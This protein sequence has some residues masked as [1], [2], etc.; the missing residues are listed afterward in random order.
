MNIAQTIPPKDVP[1][2][3]N[4]PKHLDFDFLRE[5]GLRHIQDLSGQ[6]WTDHNV[7]DPG[8]TI[9]EVLCYALTDLTYRTQLPDADLF[10]PNPK[11]RATTGDDNF[12]TAYTMLSCNPLTELDW[13]KL[14]LDIKGV[15]NAWFVPIETVKTVK[16]VKTE[17][18]GEAKD[19]DKST[20]L[21]FDKIIEQNTEKQLWKN[22]LWETESLVLLDKDKTKLTFSDSFEKANKDFQQSVKYPLSIRGVYKIRLELEQNVEDKEP[23]LAEVNRRLAGHRNLCEDFGDISIVEDE[24][25]TICGEFELDATAQP[26]TVMLDLFN[27]IQE[28]FSPTIKF[29]TLRQMLDNGRTMEEIFEGR[30]MMPESHGFVDTA[31]LE[32]LKLPTEIR[33]SDLY[34]LI[35]GDDLKENP[36]GLQKIAGI[37]AI[38]KLLVINPK[39]DKTEQGQAWKV[40]ITEGARP[41][42]NVADSIASITFF[43][44]GVPYKVNSARVVNLFEKRLENPSKVSYNLKEER[45]K[46]RQNLDF[47]APT[48]EYRADLGDHVSIQGDFPVVYGIGESAVPDSGGTKRKAQAAQ[49]K[50][51]LTFFDHLLANY[52]AQVANVRTL[53]SP[54]LT[55]DGQPLPAGDAAEIAWLGK[56]PDVFAPLAPVADLRASIPNADALFGFARKENAVQI[57]ASASPKDKPLFGE[58]EEIAKSQ[59]T[60]ATPH[61]RDRALRQ[62]IADVDSDLVRIDTKTLSKAGELDRF[63]F[64]FVSQLGRTVTIKSLKTYETIS[65]AK[66]AAQAVRFVATL[67]SS[68]EKYDHL[69]ASP[70]YYDFK[71]IEDMGDVVAVTGESPPYYDFKLIYRP[72]QYETYLRTIL[73]DEATFFKQKNR[74]F[75]HLLSRF[76]EDFTDYTLLTFA[77]LRNNGLQIDTDNDVALSRRFALDKAHFLEKYPEIS[78]NRAK[79]VDFSQPLWTDKNQSGLENRVSKLIGIADRDTKTLNYFDIAARPT[80]YRFVIS[81]VYYKKGAA[82]LESIYTP[83]MRSSLTFESATK[84]ETARLACLE[85][86]KN[87]AHFELTF[88]TIEKVYGFR[89]LDDKGCPV[90]ESVDTFGSAALRDSKLDYTHGLFEGDGVMR[91]FRAHTEG[92]FF[93]IADGSSGQL[94]AAK[95]AADEKT[96]LYSLME[97]LQALPI[98]SNWQPLDEATERGYSFQIVVNQKVVAY[99]DVFSTTKKERDIR[100]KTTFDFFKQKKR[101]WQTTQLPQRYRWHLVGVDKKTLLTARHYFSTSKQSAAAWQ[102]AKRAILDSHFGHLVTHR[103]GDRFGIALHRFLKDDDGRTIEGEFLILANAIFDRADERDAAI[104]VIIK[105]ANTLENQADTN[106]SGFWQ[107]QTVTQ[108]GAAIIDTEAGKFSLNLMLDG[109]TDEEGLFG[110]PVFEDENAALAA[111]FTVLPPNTEG[112]IMVVNVA[113][114]ADNFTPFTENDGCIASFNVKNAETV[115]A[116]FEPFQGNMDDAIKK[117]DAVVK[118]AKDHKLTINMSI[119]VDQRWFEIMDETCDEQI[120]PILRGEKQAL[121]LKG[122]KKFYTDFRDAVNAGTLV[123]KGVKPEESKEVYYVEFKDWAISVNTFDIHAVDNAAVELTALLKSNFKDEPVGFEISGDILKTE[124]TECVSNCGDMPNTLANPNRWRL[125]DAEAGVARYVG[126]VFGEKTKAEAQPYL[127]K[128]ATDY[129]CQKPPFSMIFENTDNFDHDKLGNNYWFILRDARHLYWRSSAVFASASEALTAFDAQHVDLLI[130]ARDIKHYQIRS[131]KVKK[132]I[133]PGKIKEHIVFYIALLGLD[134]KPIAESADTATDTEGVNDLIGKLQQ[135]ALVY[136]IVKNADGQFCFQLFEP[137]KQEVIWRSRHSFEKQEA[138]KSAFSAFLDMLKYGGNFRLVTSDDGCWTRIEIVE[139]LL[140]EVTAQKYKNKD[141]VDTIACDWQSVEYFID[142]LVDAGDAAFVPTV[143][144]L[145]CC[146]Y[147][148]KLA[149]KDYRL[150]RHPMSFHSKTDRERRRDDLWHAERCRK[151]LI[152]EVSAIGNIMGYIDGGFFNIKQ[153]DCSWTETIKIKEG[154]I[155][156]EIIKKHEHWLYQLELLNNVST[157]VDAKLVYTY[158]E[159]FAWYD[160]PNIPKSNEKE[161]DI[162]EQDKKKVKEEAENFR[163]HRQEALKEARQ[164]M[165]NYYSWLVLT[166]AN[167]KLR[168]G[169]TRADGSLIIVFDEWTA[170]NAAEMKTEI[171]KLYELINFSSEVTALPD[172]T[173]GFEIREKTTDKTFIFING[174]VNANCDSI[175]VELPVFK[176]I[177]RNMRTYKTA[178]EAQAAVDKVHTLLKDKAN[179]ARTTAA[180][181]SP[182]LEIVDPTKVIALHPRTYTTPS[183]RETAWRNTRRHINTEGM[184]VVEHLLLRPRYGEGKLTSKERMKLLNI[185][186]DVEDT[187]LTEGQKIILSTELHN[188][189]LPTYLIRNVADNEPEIE[190]KSFNP[191]DDDVDFNDYILGADPYSFWVTVV[192][193]HWSARFRDLDFRDFFQ[194][195]LRREAP[196]H[197]ALN[198]VWVNPEQMLRFEKV[199]RSWLEVAADPTHNLYACRKK[200]LL[201]VF[202]NLKSITPEAGLLDCAAGVSS[203]LILLDKTTLR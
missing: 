142:D 81:D 150:A 97:C 68:F 17:K 41:T 88:C 7:H 2:A 148:F 36:K 82:Q 34:H 171:E 164:A 139:V 90:A 191:S 85:L 129:A 158:E 42:L 162:T 38:K 12:P 19:E 94:R 157:D 116:T 40:P 123:G 133:R 155:E 181:G 111:T 160:N 141:E 52:L 127:D 198:I 101:F 37:S 69:A 33:V 32:A 55:N 3:P 24:P 135:H 122:I 112:V 172:G 51:Y 62:L 102:E 99:D 86:G 53:F 72:P 65:E 134:G 137:E 187:K 43:K 189:L 119:V 87:I 89:L 140:D 44:R 184:H 48:G 26:D 143:D 61:D 170:N 35:L 9:M 183:E 66:A 22:H 202:I 60:Y 153:K 47:A 131:R 103:V 4:M 179:Y 83:L 28:F 188:R 1:F 15:R 70:P 5:E 39:T 105:L 178:G 29:Y 113:E 201:E 156:K 196:A 130:L 115:L 14:L 159:V 163:I 118:T 79:A 175:S 20:G 18:T 57:G 136:P 152:P 185:N 192:L 49:L 146:G 168:L 98:R 166:E 73:E 54:K 177:W 76:A 109:T 107:S 174:L 145:N 110:D 25:L 169:I 64:L 180:E 194:G 56:S 46:G 195:S 182:T 96:A 58:G 117:R 80:R 104:D 71:L 151:A 10:A 200:C 161:D 84:A 23:I 199:W 128:L 6:L 144:Y 132:Q 147:G 77:T 114:L 193:P 190:I 74:L 8:I 124:P 197:V 75:D 121:D 149:Q 154:G 78:R 120:V 203:K 92:V 167:G 16:T 11:D 21:V 108:S 100:L 186:V 173:F 126:R 95:G 125:S 63:Y 91:V 93:E 176:V 50:G 27:R 67:E 31:E 59:N 45:L 106:A 165:P 30:P 138:A 13:R